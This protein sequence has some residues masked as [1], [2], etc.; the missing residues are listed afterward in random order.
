[1]SLLHFVFRSKSFVEFGAIA[2]TLHLELYERAPFSGLDM[3]FFENPPEF[4]LVF[5]EISD[6]GVK[7]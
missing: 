6:A 7:G 1:M 3:V 2:D 4:P 5:H